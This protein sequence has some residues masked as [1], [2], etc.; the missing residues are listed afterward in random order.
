MTFTWITTADTGPNA[1]RNGADR[2]K[3]C[4]VITYK[5]TEPRAGLHPAHHQFAFRRM[6]R[7]LR[8][9]TVKRCAA[10]PA[11]PPGPHPGNE[12]REL[13][14]E[15]Q[16]GNRRIASPGRSR[17]RT[18]RT[19]SAVCSYSRNTQLCPIYCR[20]LSRQW[21]KIPAPQWPNISAPL[22]TFLDKLSFS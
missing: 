21:Y 6:G 9:A 4:R 18:S 22:T 2:L 8:L 3:A 17:R 16:Q 13:S 19:A 1:T 7:G 14:P 11:H 20:L 12:R 15:A 10:G 5:Q